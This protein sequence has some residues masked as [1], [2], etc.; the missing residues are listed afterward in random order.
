MKKDPVEA[1]VNSKPTWYHVVFFDTP[2]VKRAWIRVEELVR[3][4]RVEEPPSKGSSVIKA[5]LKVKWKK[6]L[7][8]AAQCSKLNRE[9]RLE[10]FS[11]AAL[12]HGKW[13]YYDEN[14]KLQGKKKVASEPDSA[15]E[16][17]AKHLRES[18][19]SDLLNLWNNNDCQERV[20]VDEWTCN[21]CQ[22][23]YPYVENI[24]VKHLKFHHMNV[25]VSG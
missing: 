22:K 6:I 16:T 3:F 12:Y 10:Q 4:E 18:K 19:P 20:T 8:M 25:E 11:F 24:I 14:T 7:S 17:S 23:C 9:Q 5:S 21:M 2:Q 13:G 1:D 15:L